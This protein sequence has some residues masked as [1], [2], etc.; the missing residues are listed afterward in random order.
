MARLALHFLGPPRI[1]LDG[2]AVHFGRRKVVALLAY[3]AVTSGSHSRDALA[4]MLWPE[5]DQSRARAYLRVAL[6]ELNRALGEGFL[7][8][9]RETA[10]LDPDADLSLDVDRFR[11]L[12][13]TCKTHGHPPTEVCPDCLSALAQAVELYCDD[14]LS[15][16]TLRDSP[17][18]DEWQFFQTEGLRQELASVLERLILEHSAQGEFEAA[19]PYARRWLALDPLHE[20]A[21]R[22]LMQLY[23]WSGQR[24]AALRQYAEC[25]NVLRDE[26]GLPPEAETTQLYEA[27]KERRDLAPPGDGRLG[28]GITQAE[29]LHKRYQLEAEIGRG[30]TGIVYR[31]RDTL[32]ERDVAVKELLATALDADGRAKLLREARAAA[33]LHHPNIVSVFDVGEAE[34]RPFIV[35]ELAEGTSLQAQPP[36]ELIET[37]RV[38]RQICS[39]LEHAHSQGIVHRDLKPEN[40]LLA[41]DGTAKLADFG[42]ARSVASRLTSEGTIAG[43]VFYLAPELALGQEFDGRADLYALGVMLYELTTGRLPFSGDDPVAVITQHLHA[44]VVPPR[45]KNP[46]IPPALDALILR[47]L[48]KRPQDRPKA[49][50]EVLA[51]LEQPDLLATDRAF[52]DELSVLERVGRGRMVGRERELGQARTL[53]HKTLSGQGQTLLVSGEPGIGKT[54]LVQEL[55]T[56]VRVAGATA[57][58]G[59]CYPEAGGPYAPFAQILRLAFQDGAA[60]DPDLPAFVLADL[61]TVAPA[62]RLHF[63]DIP[64]NPPLDP[65]TE[66]QRLFESVIAFCTAL[67]ERAPL[68]LVLEDVQWADSDT[69]SLFMQ[70]ARRAGRHRLMLA[71]TY[72]EVELDSTRSFRQVQRDLNREGHATRINLSQLDRAGAEQLLATLFDE[73]ITPQFLDTIYHETEGNPFFVIEV[74][75]ALV[76]SGDLYHADGRWKRRGTGDLRIP[77]SVREAVQSRLA[78]LPAQAQ[79]A[80]RVAAV[81]GR[82]FDFDTLASA[83]KLDDEALINALEVAERAQ[84]IEEI[85]GR[86]EIAFTFAHTLIPSTLYETTSALRRRRLHRSV[87]AAIEAVHPGDK[88]R[89]A[90][91]AHHYAEAGDQ[92]LARTAYLQA[93]DHAWVSVAL[94]EAAAYFQAALDRWP[95]AEGSGRAETLRKLAEYL[96][97][98]GHLQE[99]LAALEESYALYETAGDRLGCGAVQ[100]LIGRVYWQLGQRGTSLTHYHNALSILE[101][102]PESVELARAVSSIS[103]MHFLASEYDEAVATG[104][105]ALALAEQLGAEDVTV[106]AL[107]NIGASLVSCGDPNRGL[108]LQQESLRRALALGLREDIDRG[109]FNLGSSYRK[110]CRYAEARE[111]YVDLLAHAERIGATLRVLSTLIQLATVDWLLGRWSATLALRP[112]ILELVTNISVPG[113]EGLSASRLFGKILIDLGQSEAARAELE[114]SL[115]EARNAAQLYPTV[116]HLAQLAQAFAVLGMDREAAATIQE[117]VGWI[118]RSSHIHHASTMPLLYACQ[119]SIARAGDAGLDDASGFVRRLERAHEQE[120]SPETDAS[121]S[122]GRGSV[123]LAE[124]DQQEAVECFRNAVARWEEMGRPYDQARALSGLGRAQLGIDDPKAAAAAFDQAL[125]IYDALAAQ[126]E[127][128]DLKQSFLNSGPV[129]EAREARAALRIAD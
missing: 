113:V 31:A 54:R 49:A 84:L 41:P 19:L 60:V 16:F 2:E 102:G 32:L 118:D 9:D 86:G 79:D 22:Q 71:A 53:W 82:E 63:P 75:K 92:E 59:A 46:D 103:A 5:Q 52:I 98:T 44:P 120:N 123:A 76:E 35:M 48:S 37:I 55:V 10:T 83:S 121:L 119:W 129:R 107:T 30:G 12:V 14:F 42:L 96:W 45:A 100:R 95:D 38:T 105:R 87:A 65:E 47:L 106:H 77:Q 67:S 13:S 64:P 4:T 110:R 81:I 36:A 21:H 33:S 127:D 122:E 40:V 50:A 68:L 34:G 111:V 15:G 104:E 28:S 69:L 88:S 89:L 109:Y 125:D 91:L 97:I 124:G 115:S 17:D 25:E 128:A 58:V 74:C 99:A 66:Q 11:E 90:G 116:P 114:S 112:Q 6:S 73:A 85:G 39:A 1:E 80:L 117:M 62:L 101:D 18:F 70:L 26:L 3:L 23:A 126:L 24:A 57:L 8:A 29:E 93:G 43:T 7:V 56:Q 20:P 94:G 78:K 27:I 108:P 61:R 51:V 72:R